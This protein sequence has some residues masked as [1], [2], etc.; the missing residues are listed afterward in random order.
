MFDGYC[1]WPFYWGRKRKEGW[2]EG[3]KKKADGGKEE[4]EGGR[5]TSKMSALSL[6][7]QILRN[8]KTRTIPCPSISEKGYL[9]YNFLLKNFSRDIYFLLSPISN[10]RKF[11]NLN[12]YSTQV[13]FRMSCFN[14]NHL[15]SSF[16]FLE[17]L[18]SCYSLYIL[19]SYI[20]HISS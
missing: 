16:Y 4:R 8:K 3:G 7:I 15:W 13:S 2:R 10:N 12:C 19:H 1:W 14:W 11:W 9:I 20:Q 5:K 6:K 18:S 17:V